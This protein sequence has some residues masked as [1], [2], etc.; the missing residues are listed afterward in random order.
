[1]RRGSAAPIAPTVIPSITNSTREAPAGA[2]ARSTASCA[3]SSGGEIE[4]R[5]GPGAD[6]VHA[7]GLRPRIE[8]RVTDD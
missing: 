4:H 1:M 8:A 2:E 6:D 3:S 7:V 5:P